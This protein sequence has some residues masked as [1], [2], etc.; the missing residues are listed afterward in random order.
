MYGYIYLTTNLVNNKK[1]VGMHKSAYFDPDY[2]GSGKILWQAIRKY[3]W[4]NF[5]VELLVECETPEDL[6]KSEESLD[7]YLPGI[8]TC[9]KLCSSANLF[10]KILPLLTSESKSL[11]Y[12]TYIFLNRSFN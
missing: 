4:E 6:Y 12:K 2:K 10:P 3:G 9:F 1:Y 8:S 7:M 5:K 11:S